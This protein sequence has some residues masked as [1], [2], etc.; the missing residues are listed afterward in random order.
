M[1]CTA[2]ITVS[3]SLAIIL[4][5]VGKK[6]RKMGKK[7]DSRIVTAPVLYWLLGVFNPGKLFYQWV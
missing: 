6:L 2:D 3:V 5:S 4:N 1:V 7:I